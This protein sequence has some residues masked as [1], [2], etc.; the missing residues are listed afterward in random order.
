MFKREDN[1][2]AGGIKWNYEGSVRIKP[3][4]FITQD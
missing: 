3:G 4:V 2:F 1:Y